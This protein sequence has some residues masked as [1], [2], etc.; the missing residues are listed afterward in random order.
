MSGDNKLEGHAA[1]SK[2]F[3]GEKPVVVILPPEGSLDDF[4]IWIAQRLAGLGYIGFAVDLSG[5]NAPGTK[6][7]IVL[8]L[9]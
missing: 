4:S 8:I 1:Y 7:T 3:P 2:S 6:V 5:E 9:K